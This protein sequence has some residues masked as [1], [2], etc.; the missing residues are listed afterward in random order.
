M[1]SVFYQ[2]GQINDVIAVLNKIQKK[3]NVLSKYIQ[4]F[5]TATDNIIFMKILS[6]TEK[7]LNP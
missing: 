2:S 3:K 1:S 7:M 4:L 5:L 6:N